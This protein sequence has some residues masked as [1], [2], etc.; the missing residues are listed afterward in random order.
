[1][2]TS[3][4]TRRHAIFISHANPEDNEFATWLSLQLTQLGYTVWCDLVRLHGGE[5]FWRDIEAAIRDE[6]IKFLFVL[7]RAANTKEGPLQELKVASI[8]AAR[9][10][11]KNF[12]VPLRIDDIPHGDMN[13]QLARLNAITFTRNWALGLRDLLSRLGKD[14]VRRTVHDPVNV[15]SAWWREQHSS[16]EGVT[17][18]PENHVSNWLQVLSPPESIFFHEIARIGPG[19][20]LPQTR[21]LFP[22][23]P[24]G[25]FLITFVDAS[26]LAAALPTPYELRRTVAVPFADFAGPEWKIANVNRRERSG[27]LAGLLRQSWDFYISQRPLRIYRLS[28]DRT[29]AFLEHVDGETDWVQFLKRDGTKGHRGLTGYKTVTDVTPDL[30]KRRYWHFALSAKPLTHPIIGFALYPHVLF[31][32]DGRN[33]WEDKGRLH[34]ARRSQCKD[35]WNA[36]WRDRIMAFLSYISD[37][38]VLFLP[39]GEGGLAVSIRPLAFRSPVSYILATDATRSHDVDDNDDESGDA[40]IDERSD[41]AEGLY[42][43]TEDE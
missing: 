4:P 39:G 32:D 36:V 1:M 17:S 27:T 30:K 12:I 43:P 28:G 15:V 41:D 40:V 19:S 10:K 37:D 21:L 8:T 23:V 20:T 6:T 31:S 38:E 42:E 7:S 5:D 9:A 35:W 18:D 33:L 3:T 16:A 11:L 24:R 29:C 26:A 34:S 13:I 14:G 25:N 2:D 22:A